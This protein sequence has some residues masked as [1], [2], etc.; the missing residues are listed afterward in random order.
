MMGF[1][2]GL[3]ALVL[4]DDGITRLLLSKM[5]D[6][7]GFAITIEETC[8]GARARV[9]GAR[10]DLIFADKNLPDGSGLDFAR[11]LKKRDPDCEVILMTADA[12]IGSVV[13]AMQ[14]DIAD[15]FVKPL[16]PLDS[17]VARVRRVVSLLDLK[18]T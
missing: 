5:L 16:D 18:R 11:D 8:A 3:R 6:R 13:D 15:Y 2:K 1:G 7:A 12:T 10:F 9:E 14:S 4:E 17:F